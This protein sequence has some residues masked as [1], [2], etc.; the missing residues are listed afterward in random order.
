[1]NNNRNTQYTMHSKIQV[2]WLYQ[3]TF[4]DALCCIE[5]KFSI[6]SCAG[7][8]MRSFFFILGNNFDFGKTSIRPPFLNTTPFRHV[9][10]NNPEECNLAYLNE[11]RLA[12][13]KEGTR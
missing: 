7:C 1:M 9:I 2:I 5:F 8:L 11:G 6:N 3:L 4:D 12:N 13:L 10:L